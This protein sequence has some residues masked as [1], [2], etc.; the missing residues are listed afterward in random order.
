M[1]I[2]LMLVS[3]K[4][5]HARFRRTTFRLAIS[6]VPKSTSKAIIYVKL[7]CN[8]VQLTNSGSPVWMLVVVDHGVK[9]VPLKPVCPDSQARLQ[10]SKFQRP[11]TALTCHG[12]LQV[13]PLETLLNIPYIWLLRVLPR[14]R[15]EIPR[16]YPVVQ[17]RW[18]K[19]AKI[20]LL[21]WNAKL[22]IWY[23]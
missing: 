3:S 15:L 7:T 20:Q 1:P 22:G 6:K 13:L 19:W 9:S 11:L 4:E 18:E 2:G 12:S 23:R 17:I 10:P 21:E 5:V 14:N 8:P 16:Q